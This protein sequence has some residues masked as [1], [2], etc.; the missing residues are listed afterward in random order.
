M[1]TLQPTL[2]ALMTGASAL[3]ST[4]IAFG[5]GVMPWPRRLAPEAGSCAASRRR[6]GPYLLLDKIAAGA[7]GEV[8]R[9]RHGHAGSVHAVKLLPRRAGARQRQQFEREARFGERLDHPNTVHVH[10][11][12]ETPDGTPWFAM[13]L[14]DGISLDDLVEQCG[15]QPARRVV[16]LLLQI[17][18]VLAEVHDQG[19]VHRDIKPGNIVLGRRPD[20]SECAKLLDFGL[21]K[22][23]SEPTSSAA[24]EHVVGTPLYIAPEALTTPDR[25]D[26][27]TDLYGLG[28]VAH[29]LLSGSPPFGGTSVVEVCAHHMLTPPEPLRN[30][31]GSAVSA[32]LERL[33]LDCLAKQPEDRPASARDLIRRLRRCPE[34]DAVTVGPAPTRRP[35]PTIAAQPG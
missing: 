33:V 8:Y 7:M 29:F 17:A 4:A 2:D 25:V 30:I 32:E 10:E 35:S 23:L 12:G 13:D 9:A 14:V 21:V 16:D 20:G 22:D 34:L 1:P 18:A 3:M 28:A 26:G 15:R 19:F 5:A 6:V 31:V 24:C 27:R 11:R